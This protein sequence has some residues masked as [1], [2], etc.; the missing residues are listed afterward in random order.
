MNYIY[1]C[2]REASNLNGAEDEGQEFSAETPRNLN[3]IIGKHKLHFFSHSLLIFQLTS[4]DLS[5]L[6]NLRYTIY[7]LLLLLLSALHD[8]SQGVERSTQKR[9]FL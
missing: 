5:R 9:F 4:K 8:V 7:E 6:R 3:A 2:T 1:E